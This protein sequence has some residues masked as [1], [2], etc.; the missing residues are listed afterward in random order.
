NG[1]AA[2][3]ALA[4]RFDGN[5]KEAR[6][7]CREQL[8]T[9]VMKSGED[10]SDFFSKMDDLRARLRDMGEN[11]PDESFEDVLLRALPKEYNFVRQTSHRDRSFGLPEIRSTVINMYIDELS[12]KSSGPSVTGRGV[13][14]A[15][16]PDN[17]QC[18]K[19]KKYGHRKRDC[20]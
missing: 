11:F 18:F 6:R 20:P 16:A 9:T 3:N 14:M 19:C 10:P 7:A 17:V 2:W 8:F 12:R 13:A 15:A 5:T 1:V 4:D